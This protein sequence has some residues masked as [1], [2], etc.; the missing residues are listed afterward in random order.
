MNPCGRVRFIHDTVREYVKTDKFLERYD[1]GDF[2][3]FQRNSHERL[4]DICAAYLH[5]ANLHQKNESQAPQAAPRRD[6]GR[7]HEIDVVIAAG[8]SD[9]THEKRIE[10]FA[11]KYP[12]IR[13]AIESILYHSETAQVLGQDQRSFLQNF[14]RR[15]FIRSLR[16]LR[17][18]DLPSY[19]ETSSLLYILADQGLPALTELETS[20]VPTIHIWGERH[21]CPLLAAIASNN[22]AVVHALLGTAALSH[23]LPAVIQ[24]LD[25]KSRNRQ[26]VPE[27]VAVGDL[28]D[29]VV[30]SSISQS[31]VEWFFN[32]H[33]TEYYYRQIFSI[34]EAGDRF[35]LDR[36]NNDDKFK[37]I[38]PDHLN[39]W[40]LIQAIQAGLF[41]VVS[42]I[43]KTHTVDMGSTW[44]DG[45]T[46]CVFMAAIW[47][48]DSQIGALVL[49]APGLDLNKPGRSG[50][51]AISRALAA[52]NYEMAKL[53]LEQDLID[54]H[55]LDHKSQT[56]L[57]L[58]RKSGDLRLIEL[59]RKHQGQSF[60]DSIRSSCLRKAIACNDVG[61][62]RLL[63]KE[64][65]NL[66][67]IA[68]NH[69]TSDQLDGRYCLNLAA[70]SGA[71][72]VL[73]IYLSSPDVELGT[74]SKL[75]R[76]RPLVTDES[77]EEFYVL[78]GL[79]LHSGTNPN[80][81]GDCLDWAF[82]ECIRHGHTKLVKR[83]I[84]AG[85]VNLEHESGG[86][87]PLMQ[88]AK[89]NRLEIM[90]LLLH[91]GKAQV[92]HSN[93]EMKS[94]LMTAAELGHADIVRAILNA[95]GVR[96]HMTDVY[97]RTAHQMALD[98]QHHEIADILEA[99][100]H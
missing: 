72:E 42:H 38:R 80:A 89:Y 25:S 92:N 86:V 59:V 6:R 46:T 67:Q 41:H 82:A 47:S 23:D 93:Y 85:I 24:I 73:Q 8:V 14:P 12:L 40:L 17:G 74:N 49:Q 3:T 36:L 43:L 31:R 48:Q 30:A 61:I 19:S 15:P 1:L 35:L 33:G 7:S 27:V 91:E 71:W 10:S 70:A 28:P 2:V 4:K 34:V 64:T 100:K 79:L 21:G 81:V 84:I 37:F 9:Q 77:P 98:Q 16:V 60:S 44:L 53:I 94:A 62:V 75:C 5:Y 50:Q 96:P 88:A 51:T 97:G 68:Q 90:E 63:I 32:K 54:V 99:S 13:Y 78:L 66:A 22:V 55:V 95:D 18:A 56:P 39:G 26:G 58:A 45:R 65:R 83:L 69:R 57:S 52:K 29:E 87:T 76:L 11:A 20:M